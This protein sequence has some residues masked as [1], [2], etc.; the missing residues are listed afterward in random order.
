MNCIGYRGI[1]T[2]LVIDNPI[3]SHD[4]MRMIITNNSGFCPNS[5]E[6]IAVNT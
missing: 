5:K 1:A 2:T 3:P 6:F 4:S